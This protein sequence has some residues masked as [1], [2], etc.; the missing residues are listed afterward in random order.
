MRALVIA[1]L[2]L[3]SCATAPAK[4]KY[5]SFADVDYGYPGE[6]TFWSRRSGVV[7]HAADV[8]PGKRDRLPIVLIHPWGTNMLVWKNVVAKLGGDRRLILIDL[9]GHGKSGKPSGEYP[10]RRMAGAVIDALD[11]AKIDRA[12]IAGNSLGGSTAIEVALLAPSRVDA[13]ILMGAPGGAPFSLPVQSA[14]RNG[15]RPR[16]LETLAYEGYVM[17]WLTMTPNMP[18]LAERLLDDAIQLRTTSEWQAWARA[19]S[20]ALR[21]VVLYAPQLERIKAPVLVIQ[22]GNDQIV[23]ADLGEALAHRIS[24]AKLIRIDTCG[25]VPEVECPLLLISAIDAF[26]N[27]RNVSQAVPSTS[28]TSASGSP[29]FK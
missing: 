12:V 22:G 1:S 16:T 21:E 20:S 26:L 27:H 3:S 18:P 19:T 25:H 28:V 17:A 6:H 14:V 8:D 13:L 29:A 15:A 10:L 9:P 2:L 5:Q 23:P 4:P 11:E 24:G 7:I